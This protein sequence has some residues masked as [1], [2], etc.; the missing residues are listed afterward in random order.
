MPPQGRRN[1]TYPTGL[2]EARERPIFKVSSLG[3]YELSWI[4][5]SAKATI[6]STLSI[7]CFE[8]NIEEFLFVGVSFHS[9]ENGSRF[10]CHKKGCVGNHIFSFIELLPY[11]SRNY[12]VPRHISLFCFKTTF[13]SQ[14]LDNLDIL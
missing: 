10:L 3:S 5:S 11:S 8:F 6:T 14:M 9:K 2:K 1:C 7:Y 12:I 4:D 13:V